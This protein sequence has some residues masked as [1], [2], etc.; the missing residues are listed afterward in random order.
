MDMVVR[1]KVWIEIDGEVVLS[2]GKAALLEAIQDAGSIQKAADRLG[3]S[4]RHAWGIIQKM[5]SRSGKKLVIAKPGGN[6]GGSFLTSEARDWLGR[7]NRFHDG[8]R[9]LVD[10]RFRSCFSNLDQT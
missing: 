5:E 10:E 8:M 7:F 2:Q 3:M 6:G 1:S 4:Y 9:E